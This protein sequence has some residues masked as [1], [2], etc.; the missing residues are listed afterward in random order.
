MFFHNADISLAD[1]FGS[2]DF[3]V[4]VRITEVLVGTNRFFTIVHLSSV[5]DNVSRKS[6]LPRVSSVIFEYRFLGR[7]TDKDA[8]LLLRRLVMF[9]SFTLCNRNVADWYSGLVYLYIQGDWKQNLQSSKNST[10]FWKRPPPLSLLRLS[11]K[12]I[13]I[14][15]GNIL[16][17][18]GRT[19]KVGNDMTKNM[20]IATD[21]WLQQ[22]LTFDREF[23]SSYAPGKN[24]LLPLLIKKSRPRTTSFGKKNSIEII[25][26][27][28]PGF[29]F[30]I[31][32][33]I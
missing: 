31:I 13:W 2:T 1:L 12:S 5:L 15:R 10:K 21:S 32:P 17:I 30:P 3:E 20:L 8:C 22:T 19:W 28:R 11:S 18:T 24:K 25:S 6:R 26:F 33:C 23:T 16:L 27:R 4:R 14:T 7:K 9:W 29:V